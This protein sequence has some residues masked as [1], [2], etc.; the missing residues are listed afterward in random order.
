MNLTRILVVSHTHWDRE[1]Y[2]SFQQFRARL[3]EMMD[4][5]LALL[6]REPRFASFTLDGQTV[7]LEDYLEVRPEK[8]A[9]FRERVQEGRLLI[10]PWYTSPDELPGCRSPRRSGE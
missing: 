10:G 1:W 7:L 8:R 9:E 6:G 2:L 5:L 3:V 4:A